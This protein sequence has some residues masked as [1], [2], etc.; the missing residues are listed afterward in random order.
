MEPI[1]NVFICFDFSENRFKMAM[2]RVVHQVVPNFIL[3]LIGYVD[4][5][6]ASFSFYSGICDTSITIQSK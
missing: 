3:I 2:V 1:I 5:N 6:T 4:P